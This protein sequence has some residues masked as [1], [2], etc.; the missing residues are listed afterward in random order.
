MFENVWIT[1]NYFYWQMNL[2]SFQQWPTW[3]I[4]VHAKNPCISSKILAEIQHNSFPKIEFSFGFASLIKLQLINTTS[5]AVTFAPILEFPFY[6]FEFHVLFHTRY[7]YKFSHRFINFLVL[8]VC[9]N[10][11]ECWVEMLYRMSNFETFIRLIFYL[12]IC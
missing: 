8:V 11:W 7:T 12:I 6:R 2:S 3:N 1:K 4:S 5:I 10:W 9:K